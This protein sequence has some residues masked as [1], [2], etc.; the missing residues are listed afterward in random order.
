MTRRSKTNR[1]QGAFVPFLA[2]RFQKLLQPVSSTL[3][4]PFLKA[5]ASMT[6]SQAFASSSLIP[7]NHSVM[8]QDLDK[9]AQAGIYNEA[10]R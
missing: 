8:N 7:D 3:P 4:F 9:S 2:V 10:N 6:P 1:A 5:W